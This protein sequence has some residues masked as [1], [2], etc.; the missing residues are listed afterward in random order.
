MSRMGLP[1]KVKEILHNQ[2][3]RLLRARDMIRRQAEEIELLRELLAHRLGFD[4]ERG[5]VVEVGTTLVDAPHL[6][7][8]IMMAM[9]AA[10]RDN[11]A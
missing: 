2:K 10:K 8:N 11:L 1:K 7:L 9:P 4:K 3:E 6:D 5:V